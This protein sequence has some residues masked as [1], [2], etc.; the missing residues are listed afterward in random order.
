MTWQ[1]VPSVLDKLLQDKD[2]E[3]STRVMKAMM[4]MDKLD[5]IS[6]D[7]ASNPEHETIVT[8]IFED[9][10]AKTLMTFRQE[11]FEPS[12]ASISLPPACGCG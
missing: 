9:Q 2:A 8:M 12:I 10:G 1:I 11:E 7:P 6:D 4:Q 5:I 3:K